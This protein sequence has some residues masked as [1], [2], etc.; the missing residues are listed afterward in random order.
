MAR[1]C[2]GAARPLAS[3]DAVY[4]AAATE[5]SEVLI[6]SLPAPVMFERRL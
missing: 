2:A 5:V 3:I 1:A 4:S 6:I